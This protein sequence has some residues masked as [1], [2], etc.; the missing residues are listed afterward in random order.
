[1]PGQPLYYATVMTLGGL[2]TGLLVECHEGRPTKTEGNPDHPASRGAATAFAQASVLTL[3]DPDRS[4]RVL[5]EGRR[6]SW[7]EFEA[8]MQERA[9]SFGKGEGLRFLSGAV[10][11]PSL[12]ALK[13]WVLDRYPKARWIEYEPL[14]RDTELAGAELAYGRTLQP[15]YRFDQADVIV[16]LDSDFLGLDCLAPAWIRD[17][18]DRRRLASPRDSMSRLY[19]VEPGYSLTGANADH[20]WRTRPSQIGRV[21]K[22]LARELGLAGT[23]NEAATGLAWLPAVA[24]D[25]VNHRG[26][27]LVL[28]GPRQPAWV[29]ALAF[30]I[31]HALGN[32]GRTVH[33]IEPVV[34][35]DMAALKG[36]AEEAG[37]GQVET[38]VILGANPVYNAPADAKFAAAIRRVP[39]SIH[40]G[41]EV[42]ET[43][44]LA[45]WHL[46]E[47]HY[48]E[49]WGDGRAFDGTAGIQQ[50]TI[51][52]L[53]GGRTA[54]EVVALVTGYAHRRAYDIVRNYWLGRW[55]AADAERAWER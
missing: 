47:A 50:P 24:R 18:A 51:A 53:F 52:P 45:T 1:M 27:S 34:R 23:S 46:P 21:A 42:D 4:R 12:T 26:R 49:S 3:Y 41:Q 43:A 15:V 9:G 37:S 31:N 40:L 10:G 32:V 44:A 19:V 48:L 29:H 13:T 20:R 36:L 14:G 39:V 35:T 17:F 25:L 33:L 5:R 8:F 11:S 30:W 38:L 16:S 2:A 55:K 54:A 22:A 28:A 7:E 6:S